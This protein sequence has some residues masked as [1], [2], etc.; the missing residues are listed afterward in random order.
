MDCWAT[1]WPTLRGD[2]AFLYSWRLKGIIF[3]SRPVLLL[4]FEI[5]LNYC[6]FDSFLFDIQG[7]F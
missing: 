1:G 3:N 5:T 2:G 6:R 4:C 7:P